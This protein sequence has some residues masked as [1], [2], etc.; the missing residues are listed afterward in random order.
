MALV[1]VHH[2]HHPN[3]AR[4]PL[5]SQYN[6]NVDRQGVDLCQ[7]KW[8]TQ[9]L[10]TTHQENGLWPQVLLKLP[11]ATQVALGSQSHKAAQVSLKDTCL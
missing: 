11:K 10:S 4:K 9:V 1:L 8:D 7:E 3:Q 2:P 6:F 5:L